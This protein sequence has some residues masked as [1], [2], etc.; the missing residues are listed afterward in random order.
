MSFEKTDRF[1]HQW[2]GFHKSYYILLFIN[3]LFRSWFWTEV[4]LLPFLTAY[5][6]FPAYMSF[7]FQYLVAHSFLLLGDTEIMSDIIRR[8]GQAA[9]YSL[10]GKRELDEVTLCLFSYLSIFAVEMNSLW[11][12]YVWHAWNGWRNIY[13]MWIHGISSDNPFKRIALFNHCMNFRQIH[14]LELTYWL[15]KQYFGVMTII[16]E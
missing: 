10:K 6:P 9:G 1:L 7:F 13:N 5:Y 15:I 2:V 4:N 14:R 3:A 12:I 11:S 16:Q 8:C